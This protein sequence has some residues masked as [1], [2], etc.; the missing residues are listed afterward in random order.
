VGTGA[1]A[2]LRQ[3]VIT[4]LGHMVLSACIVALMHASLCSV[5]ST[6]EEGHGLKERRKS[7]E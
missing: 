7:H 2:G 1:K 5:I 3:Q 6:T 4:T